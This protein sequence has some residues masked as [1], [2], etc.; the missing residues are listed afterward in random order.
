ML[1]L[2]KDTERP[3]LGI[4][5]TGPGIPS[6]ERKMVLD[7]FYRVEQSRTT[8]GSG[9]GLALVKAVADLHDASL[10]LADN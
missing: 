7:R 9:L 1:S 5:D 10:E 4:A 2:D 3:R 6:E 8:P